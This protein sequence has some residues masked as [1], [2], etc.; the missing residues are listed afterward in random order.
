MSAC[1]ISG[2][3]IGWNGIP[4]KYL[5]IKLFKFQSGQ[6]DIQYHM[7]IQYNIYISLYKAWSIVFYSMPIL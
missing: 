3:G 7:N 2:N 5:R 6:I 1:Y 4:R